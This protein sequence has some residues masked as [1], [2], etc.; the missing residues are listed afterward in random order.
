MGQWL[1]HNGAFEH[2]NGAVLVCTYYP[3][4]YVQRIHEEYIENNAHARD[5][6]GFPDPEPEGK[7]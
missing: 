3:T 2:D 4:E 1:P 5:G 7:P 6:T